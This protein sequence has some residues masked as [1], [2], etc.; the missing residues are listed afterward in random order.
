MLMDGVGRWAVALGVDVW[1]FNGCGAGCRVG[2]SSV[3]L[4]FAGLIVGLSG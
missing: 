3:V 2:E 1:G 4:M